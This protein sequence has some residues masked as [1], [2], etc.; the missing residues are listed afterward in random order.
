MII[1]KNMFCLFIVFR[2]KVFLCSASSMGRRDVFVN[3]LELNSLESRRRVNNLERLEVFI[4]LFR[5]FLEFFFL[6]LLFKFVC[7]SKTFLMFRIKLCLCS[8]H[9]LLWI[10]TKPAQFLIV[11][12][13]QI[14]SL[15]A[16]LLLDTCIL[17]LHLSLKFLKPFILWWKL[18]KV[19]LLLRIYS[20]RYL[21]STVLFS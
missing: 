2:R 16:K 15:V 7:I 9:Y 5:N 12:G 20:Q 14:R 4:V 8:V 11:L 13:L 18:F 3:F 6:L 19:F 10:G 1:L 17:F 21:W